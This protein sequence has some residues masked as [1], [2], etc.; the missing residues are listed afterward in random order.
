MEES[1][2]VL[3]RR[4]THAGVSAFGQKARQVGTLDLGELYSHWECRVGSCQADVF[5]SAP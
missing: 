5:K 4:I 1:Y 3:V 2:L